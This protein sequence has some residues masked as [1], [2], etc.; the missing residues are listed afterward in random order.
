MGEGFHFSFIS[1]KYLAT[2]NIN[3]LQQNKPS[4][5]VI[6]LQK[7]FKVSLFFVLIEYLELEEEKCTL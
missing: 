4:D 5:M 1:L 6:D 2:I 7:Y 3:H